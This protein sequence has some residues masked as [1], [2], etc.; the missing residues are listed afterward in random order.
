MKTTKEILDKVMEVCEIV[1]PLVYRCGERECIKRDYEVHIEHL[2]LTVHK[3]YDGVVF[4]YVT[5]NGVFQVD[6][7]KK[8]PYSKYD[9]QKTVE[10]NL[11]ENESL[12]ELISNLIFE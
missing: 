10:Q 5:S 9:L 12:R 11:N 7:Y 2:L 1:E 3:R 4:V 8:S 6:G